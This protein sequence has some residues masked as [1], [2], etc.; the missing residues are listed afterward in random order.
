MPITLIILSVFVISAVACHFMAKK[1]DGSPVFWGVMGLMFGPFAIMLLAYLSKKL[2][3]N[4][5]I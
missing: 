2:H 1:R 5:K 4:Y 3:N